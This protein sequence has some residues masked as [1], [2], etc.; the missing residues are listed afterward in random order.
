MYIFYILNDRSVGLGHWPCT[1]LMAEVQEH[2][3]KEKVSRE[4]LVLGC[5]KIYSNPDYKIKQQKDDN[6]IQ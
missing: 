3:K 6:K 5:E 2:I 1:L 4:H